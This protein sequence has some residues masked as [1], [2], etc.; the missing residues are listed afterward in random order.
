MLL[1]Y[2]AGLSAVAENNFR[3]LHAVLRT[4][5]T[6]QTR[7]GRNQRPAGLILAD[8]AAEMASASVFEQLPDY[9][10]KLV[11]RSEYLFKR[12]QP[13]LEDMLFLGREYEVEFDRFEILWALETAQM[14]SRLGG[15]FWGPLGRFTWKHSRT[16]RSED[17]FARLR[18]KAD[19][20]GEDWPPLTAGLFEGSYDTFKRCW[21]EYE[22]LIGN[23]RFF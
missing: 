18:K 8:A 23:M 6:V 1:L 2:S 10:E 15:S 5:A 13:T 20:A 22:Q 19:A 4:E 21:E 7:R 14:N 17:A 16:L 11:P 9:R 3:N 12:L